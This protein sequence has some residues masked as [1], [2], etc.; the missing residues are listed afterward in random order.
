MLPG[1]VLP[2]PPPPLV[3]IGSPSLPQSDPQS[4]STGASVAIIIIVIIATI[5]LTTCFV[6]LR[7][8]CLRRQGRLSS[9]SFSCCSSESGMRSAAS[10]AVASA[11]SSVARSAE[12]PVEGSELVASV[13]VSAEMP[14][15]G[16]DTLVPSALYLPEVERLILELL[17]LPAVPMKPGSRDCAMCREFLP[18]DVL[19]I[20]P[21]CSHMFHQS[22]I[23]NWLRH[24]TPSC[25]PSCHASITIPGSNKTEVA[26]TFCSVEYDIE[27]QMLMPTPPGEAVA[28]AVGGD[29]GWL[30]S[31]LD[32]LSGSWRG[33][34]SNCAT[35]AVVPV[36]S[37]CTTGSWSQGS[38]GRFDNDSDC[39]KVQEPLPVTDGKEVPET[40][41]GSVG[42][43][44]S[45]AT[46]SGSWSGCSSSYSSEM[47][48]P[49]TSRHVTETLASS[50][51]S[52]TDT[53][54]RRWDLEAAMPT[55]ERPSFRSS[56]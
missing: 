22:C 39:A 51:R 38:N 6:L 49:V 31:S 18:T 40:V 13:P 34:S 48:L 41:R 50:G 3:F 35:A 33:C 4:S 47:G 9:S 28:E 10:A 11:V 25:C 5:T 19:L 52:E 32:R 37:R 24:T 43:L 15:G 55:P 27:S 45:L 17:S 42:W 21:L 7:R 44:R 2:P 8:G 16:M 46:L 20:L 53:W 14:K 36:S 12:G 1:P 23:I 26:P 54:S 30:R 29:H 56:G